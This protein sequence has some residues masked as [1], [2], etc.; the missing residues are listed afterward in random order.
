ME[1][2][3]RPLDDQ[4]LER[5]HNHG[6][7]P[8]AAL[9]AAHARVLST[10]DG[11]GRVS[12]GIGAA[13]RRLVLT[14]ADGPWNDLLTSAAEPGDT[15]EGAFRT[16]VHAYGEEPADSA[17]LLRVGWTTAGLWLTGATDH[18]AAQRLLD[19]HQAAL[20]AIAVDPSAGHQETRL[21]SDSEYR[22]QVDGL[23]GP[24]RPL[25]DRRVHELF[26]Q[27]VRRHPDRVGATFGVTTW[28][29]DE[30][31]RRANR[32]A[33]RLLAR[34]VT[35]E[36]VVGV[37]TERTLDWLACVLGVFKAGAVY[38]PIEPQFPAPRVAS[39]L[40][41][42]GAGLVLAERPGQIAGV[43]VIPLAE[44]WGDAGT[45]AD[46][47]PDVPVSGDQLAYIYFTSGSTGEPKGAMCE[48]AGML[49]H[50]LAKIED[51]GLGERC[52]VA[53]TAPQCFD[54][55]LWQLIAPL[56]AGGRVH[57]VPQADL[58]DVPRFVGVLA[59]AGIEVV[60]LVPS[61]LD[62]LLNHLTERRVDLPRLR[63]VSVTGEALRGQLVE[64]WFARFPDIPLLN[65]YGLTE[66]SDDTNHALLTG[67]PAE[68]RVPL[69]RP[70]RN[71][72]EYV[73]DERMQPVPL[74]A[75][76]EIVFSGVCVGRGYINDQERTD[77]AFI[78]DPHRPGARLYRSG[79]YGRWLPDGTLEFLG[80]RDSQVKVRGYRI[81]IGEVEGRLLEVPTVR[82][83]A[84]VVRAAGADARLVGFYSG[85][86]ATPTAR[87][88][89]A[90]GA[91]LPAYM[92]PAELV[93]IDTLPL[94]GNGKIDRPALHRL[95]DGREAGTPADPPETPAERRVAHAW[96]AALGVAPERVGRDHHFFQQ[97]GTS[98]SALRLVAGLDHDVSLADVQA[99]PVLADL[100]TRLDGE[101]GGHLVW[102][103]GRQGPDAPTVLCVPAAGGNAVNFVHLASLLATDGAVV[104][105]VEPP[106]PEPTRDGR[107]AL[108]IAALAVSVTDDL[109][110]LRPGPVVLWG[111]SAGTAL[112]VETAVLL[113]R[114]GFDVRVVFLGAQ[115][116]GTPEQRRGEL[117]ST[118]AASD[119]DLAADLRKHSGSDSPELHLA[120]PA[121]RRDVVSA[122][123][124]FAELPDRPDRPRLRAAVVVVVSAAD[125]PDADTIRASY[126]GWEVVASR[127]RLVELPDGG[128]QF[129]RSR[130][131]A[132]ASI[133]DQEWGRP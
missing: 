87:I 131:E 108:D 53:Q 26:E 3:R 68:G 63:V 81:E 25:P 5:L 8:D 59:D 94:T 50:M 130:A 61:Y 35:A 48:H 10:L 132:V 43:P 28:T 51:L 9:A 83:A 115:T 80:R 62:V 7:K 72:V 102:L 124:W 18:D 66:T 21:I 77:Q 29:Y 22:L 120:L 39:M 15:V 90:L 67:P 88:R 12:F 86:P 133:I 82:E 119:D 74:G 129:V 114:A 112:A 110:A 44:L 118:L 109:A 127:V 54:I 121:Y 84:V 36:T 70:V 122:C 45:E 34:E 106:G 60:Q 95:L 1:F 100:A 38:L 98:L 104:Y 65:A 2:A 56:L 41:R 126:Q 97:G 42:S 6:V 27:R 58:V 19:Y 73:V 89:A 113:E 23:G 37:L 125:D 49:N 76:G 123:R 69:G 91:A 101:A 30:I 32:V 55:S 24:V 16:V 128:H 52:V 31:N 71:V 11:T 75:P 107:P 20:T 85:S 64:R 103:A 79:D 47:N 99:H 105:G 4:L 17:G 13:G 116:P 14:V 117:A 40:S 33:R 92:V 57:L 96:A 46:T 111:H 78:A 93:W